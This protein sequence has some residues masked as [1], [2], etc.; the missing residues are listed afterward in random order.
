MYQRTVI[1]TVLILLACPSLAAEG[2]PQTQASTAPAQDSETIPEAAPS[3]LHSALRVAKTGRY[4]YAFEHLKRIR[5]EELSDWDADALGELLAHMIFRP[6]PGFSLGAPGLSEVVG[7]C[8]HFRLAQVSRCVEV[9]ARWAIHEGR[10]ADALEAWS[11]L[12]ESSPQ[13]QERLLA[14]ALGVLLRLPDRAFAADPKIQ[15]GAL[16]SFLDRWV[17]YGPLRT[18]HELRRA[19]VRLEI[20][21]AVESD[22]ALEAANSLVQDFR[23]DPKALGL[24]GDLEVA[25]RRDDRALP[26]LLWAA[27]TANSRLRE[28]SPSHWRSLGHLYHRLGWQEAAQEAFEQ[29]SS[30]PP[31]RLP[32]AASIPDL[33]PECRTWH[34]GLLGYSPERLIREEG[35]QWATFIE[36]LE[37]W[38]ER[39]ELMPPNPYCLVED[40]SAHKLPELAARQFPYVVFPSGRSQL[41]LRDQAAALHCLADRPPILPERLAIL[42]EREPSEELAQEP[43]Y[44]SAQALWH[45][46]PFC[47]PVPA[48]RPGPGRQ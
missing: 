20:K 18:Q 9:R 17:H 8:D 13:D 16:F 1:I 39:C 40:D 37:E 32:P 12:L 19:G 38:H 44:W 42:L 24:R 45:L 33:S 46:R 22:R 15:D 43:D 26:W 36:D 27:Y 48:L 2:P 28:D 30:Q 35:A 23:A 4:L 7:L 21:L 29:A 34:D 25:R 41:K 6:R 3:P 47:G 10:I 5:P 11:Q 14:T 31:S